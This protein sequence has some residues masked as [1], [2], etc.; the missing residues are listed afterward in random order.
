MTEV[1]SGE[2]RQSGSAAA[3]EEIEPWVSAGASADVLNHFDVAF[4]K[5][6]YAAEGE[7]IAPEVL[8]RTGSKGQGGLEKHHAGSPSKAARKARQEVQAAL[9]PRSAKTNFKVPK[10]R[11]VTVE[12][13]LR[14]V[15]EV[16]GKFVGPQFSVD[17]DTWLSF[18]WSL[19]ADG[20]VTVASAPP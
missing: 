9:M 7:S 16:L 19:A 2:R 1:E 15:N 20:D 5:L 3:Q 14:L 11:F 13:G 18:V 6:C 4:E 8:S 17:E 10:K 12:E